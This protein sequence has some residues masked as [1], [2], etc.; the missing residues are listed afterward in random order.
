MGT[1]CMRTNGECCIQQQHALLCPAFQVAIAMGSV[2]HV[3]VDFLEDIL[4]RRGVGATLWNGKAEA[5][6]LTGFVVGI[7]TKQDYFHLIKRTQ[8]ECFENI[9]PVWIY[10]LVSIFVTDKLCE[11]SKIGL[12]KLRPQGGFPGFFYLYVHIRKS[13]HS[14]CTMRRS[15]RLSLFFFVIGFCSCLLL[16]SIVRFIDSVDWQTSVFFPREVS[17]R[18][19]TFFKV[20]ECPECKAISREYWKVGSLKDKNEVH[21][22]SAQRLGIQPYSSNGEFEEKV[23][24]QLVW[25]KLEELD[26]V[27]QTYRLKNLTHSY[28]YLVPKAVDLLDEIGARFQARLAASNLPPYYMMISSVLRTLESQQGLGKRNSNATRSISSH[29][30]GTSFDISYKEF[31]PLHE[32]KA[33][34][35]YCRHDMMRHP[36]AEVLTEMSE[37][38][39]CRVVRE[40]KQACFHITVN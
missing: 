27:A 32:K 14:F 16:I 28:P 30:Y 36:L 38:G 26:S 8:V 20:G 23:K 34:E 1:G 25:G 11:L 37:E 2:A 17:T 4:Q 29:V 9:L 21:L 33:P 39:K 3:G 15:T 19:A 13:T 7:L 18:E 5:M 40:V 35:G 12:F 22:A 10:L 24:K 31:L 6:R